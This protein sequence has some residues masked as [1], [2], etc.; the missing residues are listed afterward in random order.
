MV[1]RQKRDEFGSICGV[2][3]SVRPRPFLK[4]AGGKNQLITQMTPYLPRRGSYRTYFEPMLG[5][6]AVFFN[7]LPE[8]AVLSDLNEELINAFQI[9]QNK[10]EDLMDVLDEHDSHKME[11]DYYYQ[12]REMNPKRMSPIKSAA[13]TI[14]LN[15]TCFNGLYRVNSK[16]QFNVPFGRYKNPKLYVRDNILAASR[17]LQGKLLIHGDYMGVLEYARDGDFIYI[18]PPY[19]PLSV[20]SSFTGY[21]SGCFGNLDQEKLSEK[22][23]ELDERGCKVMLSNSSTERIK[24]L[25]SDFKIITLRAI[26]AINCKGEGRGRIDEVLVINY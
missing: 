20:T 23:R 8:R 12:V 5:G 6:G 22:F 15:K 11:K 25:Y 17:S 18:D 7:L 19:D 1:K 21:T 9:V 3:G 24:S 26:R 10:A 16:N 4:W 13:R 2:K 14:F